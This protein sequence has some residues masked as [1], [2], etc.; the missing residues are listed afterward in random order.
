[1]PAVTGPTK[2]APGASKSSY[3][4]NGRPAT[5][6]EYDVAQKDIAKMQKDINENPM[7]ALRSGRPDLISV[8]GAVNS[9]G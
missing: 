4:V 3:R 8:K 5:K 6:E 1:M 9:P 7:L 2:L